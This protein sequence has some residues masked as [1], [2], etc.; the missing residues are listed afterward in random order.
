[1][2][3]YELWDMKSR[4]AVGEFATENEALAAVR[5]ALQRHGHEYVDDLFLGRV[6]RGRSTPVAQGQNLAARALA[7]TSQALT[8]TA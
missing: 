6:S 7:A 8:A 5:E 1:V 4:N 3:S 2:V